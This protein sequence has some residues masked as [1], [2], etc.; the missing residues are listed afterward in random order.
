MSIRGVRRRSQGG[1]Q[2]S[3][4]GLVRPSVSPNPSCLRN[5]LLIL[6]SSLVAAAD[7]LNE[8]TGIAARRIVEEIA[9]GGNQ[10]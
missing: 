9:M 10:A 7:Q 2:R 5:G 4:T 8:H 1:V 6:E 3:R